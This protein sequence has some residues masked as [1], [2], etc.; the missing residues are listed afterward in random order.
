MSFE[1][2][3]TFLAMVL[4]FMTKEGCDAFCI[5][6]PDGRLVSAGTQEQVQIL[7]GAKP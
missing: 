6:L 7:M 5:P 3:A 4:D 1:N 2:R